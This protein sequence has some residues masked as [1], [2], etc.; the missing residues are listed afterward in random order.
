M[1]TATLGTIH[2]YPE[3]PRVFKA[4]I[5]AKYNNVSIAQNGN[6]TMGTTNKSEEFLEKFPMGKVP[7]FVSQESYHILW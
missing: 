1:T 5:A 7:A 4:L 6:F 2:S 3:N